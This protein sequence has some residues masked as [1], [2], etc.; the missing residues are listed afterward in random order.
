MKTVVQPPK[1]VLE[2]SK[3]KKTV[4]GMVQPRQPA[5]IT[6]MNHQGLQHAVHGSQGAH[7]QG[8]KTAFFLL[9]SNKVISLIK[10]VDNKPL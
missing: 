9:G 8:G 7:D 10:G 3:A 1:T 5:H 6:T 2:I 4:T